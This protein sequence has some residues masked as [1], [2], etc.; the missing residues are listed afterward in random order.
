MHQLTYLKV[1][2]TKHTIYCQKKIRCVCY[3]CI[4]KRKRNACVLENCTYANICEIKIL[5]N[6]IIF[7]AIAKF[8]YLIEL[9]C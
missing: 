3:H 5:Y 9:T 7:L 6:N 4:H 1:D 2:F 8:N